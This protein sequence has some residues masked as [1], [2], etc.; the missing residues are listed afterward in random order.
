MEWTQDKIEKIQ[1]ELTNAYRAFILSDERMVDFETR[2]EKMASRAWPRPHDQGIPN[3]IVAEIAEEG[4]RDKADWH[5][6]LEALGIDP[7]ILRNEDGR[8]SV[9]TPHWELGAE[10][11]TMIFADPSYLGSLSN[12]LQMSFETA[13]KILV[14][15]L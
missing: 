4:R 15:G 12:A 8:L 6:F 11:S 14:M 13:E 9:E 2:M 7:I 1:Q 3:K 5:S 10:T